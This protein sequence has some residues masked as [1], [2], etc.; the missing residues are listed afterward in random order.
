LFGD[1]LIVKASEEKDFCLKFSEE[2]PTLLDVEKVSSV[3]DNSYISDH[4]YHKIRKDL[5]LEK[6][7]P[8]TSEIRKL[9]NIQN[10]NQ[11]LLENDYGVFIDIKSKLI[12]ELSIKI[13]SNQLNISNNII[14]LKFCGDG[15]QV[16][17]KLTIFNFSFAIISDKKNCKSS[18]G[19]YIVGVFQITETYE[20]LR[21]SL[22]QTIQQIEALNKL[23]VNQHEFDL[24][25]RFANDLKVTSLL[26]GLT[27]ANSK[28]PCAYCKIR[29]PVNNKGEFSAV[30]NEIREFKKILLEKDWNLDNTADSSARCYRTPEE[31][32]ILIGKSS[33]DEKKG[34]LN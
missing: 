20:N 3:K 14:K 21:N 16:S 7:L 30:E 6:F 33:V 29:F 24:D 32:A 28:F 15:A 18:S 19:H 11:T 8:T 17:K 1:I 25:I 13:E 23:T 22:E 2:P 27:A 4:V 5:G 26:M 34:L 9:R 10:S 31:A 12:R